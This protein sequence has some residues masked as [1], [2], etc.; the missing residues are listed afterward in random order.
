MN[1]MKKTAKKLL[2][3]LL[4]FI[5][6]LSGILP[7]AEVFGAPEIIEPFMTLPS[8]G[9]PPRLF[10]VM[11]Q[12]LVRG[13]APVGDPTP[14]DVGII[15]D[16][17][18][19]RLSTNVPTGGRWQIRYHPGNNLHQVVLD[20]IPYRGGLIVIYDIDPGDSNIS[21]GDILREFE[22]WVND[23]GVMDYVDVMDYIRR[24]GSHTEVNQRILNVIYVDE[25]GTEVWSE[26]GQTLPVLPA[27]R[28]DLFPVILDTVSLTGP[29]GDMV[30]GVLNRSA[31][32]GN[33][34]R[35]M[36]QIG[37]G[38][39][40]TFRVG[41][42]MHH[43]R[44]NHLEHV[45]EFSADSFY[46]GFLYQIDLSYRTGG[47]GDYWAIP[48]VPPPPGV[49]EAD[50]VRRGRS[51]YVNTGLRDITAIPRSNPVAP[52]HSANPG[53]GYRVRDASNR[54]FINRA[55]PPPELTPP[56]RE[57][58]HFW[59]GEP[60]DMGQIPVVD[61]PDYPFG[62]S[63]GGLSPRGNNTI[64]TDPDRESGSE[65]ELLIPI[66]LLPG[67]GTPVNP[68]D[69]GIADV[70]PA[71][72]RL[73]AVRGNAPMHLANPIISMGIDNFFAPSPNVLERVSIDVGQ[74]ADRRQITNFI[75]M[76]RVDAYDPITGQVGIQGAYLSVRIGN[77]LPGTL[78]GGVSWVRLGGTTPFYARDTAVGENRVFTFP[79]FSIV[80]LG[81]V[82]N[83]EVVPFG[84]PGFALPGHYMLRQEG[85]GFNTTDIS[86]NPP[87]VLRDFVSEVISATGGET[88]IRLPLETGP[89]T[90]YYQVLFSHQNPFSSIQT[91]PAI[92]GS[93]YLYSQKLRYILDPRPNA[94][95]TP[96]RFR[97]EF[98]P[99]VPAAYHRQL[100][101]GT[102]RLAWDMGEIF[103]MSRVFNTFAIPEDA[104]LEQRTLTVHYHVMRTREPYREPG[105]NEIFATIEAEIFAGPAPGA[106]PIDPGDV[107]RLPL[108][109]TFRLVYPVGQGLRLVQYNAD[110]E[111]LA[112][113]E[114]LERQELA[115]ESIPGRGLRYMA[116][117]VLEV[118]TIRYPRTITAE[119]MPRPVNVTRPLPYFPGGVR[120]VENYFIFPNI[121]FLNVWP[122][123]V[124][125]S[126]YIAGISGVFPSDTDSITINDFE[127][128]EVPPPQSLRVS[129]ETNTARA[130]GDE[131]DRRS[132]DVWW[133]IPAPEVRHFLDHSYGFDRENGIMQMTLYIAE[134]E[135]TLRNFA[136][137]NRSTESHTNVSPNWNPA[138][139][140]HRWAGVERVVYPG[141]VE[142]NNG[143]GSEQVR[144]FYFSEIMDN[145]PFST[146]RHRDGRDA[147]R[148]DRIVAITNIP[149][150]EGM[151][152][153]DIIV[154]GG[155]PDSIR[156]R[157][158]GLDSN[159]RYYIFAD[160]IIYQDDAQR[161]DNGVIIPAADPFIR[162]II[163]V[164]LLS[165]MAGVVI[166]GEREVPDGL[167]MPPPA[168]DLRVNHD[169]TTLTRGEIYWNRVVEPI[170][171]NDYYEQY[172]DYE[173]IRIQANQMDSAMLT[174][175]VPFVQVFNA[176]PDEWHR[177]GWVEGLRTTDNGLELELWT[178]VEPGSPAEPP[179]VWNPGTPLRLTDPTLISNTLY[180]YYVRTVRTVHRLD[181]EG[182]VT[183]PPIVTFSEW[184]HVTLTTIIAPAPRN[185]TIRHDRIEEY[186]PQVQVMVGFEAP[187]P[188]ETVIA[189]GFGNIH[190]EYQVR[191]DDEEW[192]T[193]GRMGEA[194]LLHPDNHSQLTDPDW[195]YFFYLISD[196]R[197]NRHYTIRVR[198]VETPGGPSLWSNE[199]VVITAPDQREMD[200]DRIVE[201]MED[202]YRR[203]L[204]ELLRR[205]YWRLEDSNARFRVVYRP[206]TFGTLMLENHG[207][208]IQLATSDRGA[209]TH[210]YYLP[211]AIIEMA[212]EQER[213][214]SITIGDVE[215]ILPPRIIDPRYNEQL[216]A[217]VQ[218]SLRDGDIEGY[219]IRVTATLIPAF[220]GV[221]GE[222][223]LSGQ[224]SFSFDAV[225]TEHNPTQWDQEMQQF[226]RREIEREVS[227]PA[228]RN[229]AR[230]EIRDRIPMDEVMREMFQMVSE[231][232][233]EI[234]LETHESFE[235]DRAFNRL[236]TILDAAF[237]VIYRDNE[238]GLVVNGYRW[239]PQI[240]QWERLE[241]INFGGF[242]GVVSNLP[243]T[244]V[245]AGRR[246]LIPGL[247]GAPNA[248]TA[249]SIITT[250]GLDE[251]LGQNIDL[252]Q[253]ATR[254]AF[255]NSV[256]RIGASTCGMSGANFL[257]G[258]GFH[259]APGGTN[260]PI[261]RQ[262][263]IYLLMAIYEI[264]TSTSIETL[265]IRNHAALNNIQGI[266]P[267]YAQALRAAFELGIVTDIFMQPNAP[268]T[269]REM[270]ELL[271]ELDR[272]VRV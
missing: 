118:D 131:V 261:S 264:R 178:G 168:P 212:N 148:N 105:E 159:A 266:N 59:P 173:I 141:S 160:F 259:I 49:T 6:S 90:V 110:G 85:I 76:N 208:Q 214:F 255:M 232:E 80:P 193:P 229:W 4:A 250:H 182:N 39:G 63:S 103:T 188:W 161:D 220:V 129:D 167:D 136:E 177:E 44:W 36:F 89:G 134:N 151:W 138:W 18:Y 21:R 137:A 149:L 186:D 61:H 201:D 117:I 165:N 119:D 112:E 92:D 170:L 163:D 230:R 190:L 233:R 8:P 191:L 114:V 262:E 78:Y 101:Y 57:F 125:N 248:A 196:L 68:A 231:F 104:P 32:E 42:Y 124:N 215:T 185:L 143:D 179:F 5:M 244:F 25:N 237:I 75:D 27:P 199:A 145:Q 116:N 35:P 202:H 260:V 99:H 254:E 195:T 271:T 58:D 242:R 47:G 140:A 239:L 180:F 41:P 81:G 257:R 183:A 87:H 200:E 174:N 31:V 147:L 192:S 2:T 238:Q 95:A 94:I 251:F 130:L 50:G 67:R 43:M 169:A 22:I 225:G 37:G 20:L 28:P 19:F 13:P 144:T 224:I 270:L 127:I 60:R 256:A 122:V 126:R 245:F 14:I 236:L 29:V 82:Y 150:P 171:P 120:E 64:P 218:R 146:P 48:L 234:I 46:R 56:L 162:R 15:E 1:K 246:I 243:G 152:E 71:E 172:L 263:A 98:Y 253:P 11:T 16:N 100:G 91:P 176:L 153:E 135:E 26:P 53:S 84:V 30:G 227:S 66:P 45:F 272:K 24:P 198:M 156:L 155:A 97:A 79:Q 240:S 108:H 252:D 132:F 184:S 197:P 210:V 52:G 222:E 123:L 12:T 157:L 73:E 54:D 128:E 70:M 187:L 211:Q 216:R 7:A 121:Y 205:P 9:Q 267:N 107:G 10:P 235:D 158:D 206:S 106:A 133:D 207:A 223:A 88:V 40:F 83:I 102:L 241:P 17:A 258:Q 226:V 228:F 51:V 265:A 181:E 33:V 221:A 62:P 164:S 115:T 72:I 204:E 113:G 38:R 86:V 65:V 93:N 194:F 154:Q 111:R 96:E 77:L 268:I 3:L 247:E 203:E 69:L 189:Q 249:F 74:D 109:A 34:P 166:P 175:R 209:H 142:N 219:Y 217:A 269:I 213:G 55:D 23:P 139:Y